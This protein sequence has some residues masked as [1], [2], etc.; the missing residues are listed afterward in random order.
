MYARHLP[1]F[2]LGDVQFLNPFVGAA[3]R[4]APT[5]PARVPKEFKEAVTCSVVGA[6]HS[7][8]KM[9]RRV[10]Q[11][12][13]NDKGHTRHHLAPQ[14]DRAKA[15]G[16]IPTHYHEIADEIRLY[17]KISAHPDDDKMSC[18]TKENW[19]QLIEFTRLIIDELYILPQKVELLRKNRN[20]TSC[21]G[22]KPRLQVILSQPA[23]H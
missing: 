13:L 9:E 20:G 14:I 5:L 3:S 8:T 17:G 1:G 6:L 15:D 4:D 23:N 11:R 22:A 2:K 10:L 12:C 21:V 19:H 16:T 18:V 7:A